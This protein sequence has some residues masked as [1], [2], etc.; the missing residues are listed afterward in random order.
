MPSDTVRS[1]LPDPTIYRF[2]QR[3]TVLKR[4]TGGGWDLHIDV[5]PGSI[6]LRY[7]PSV[8]FAHDPTQFSLTRPAPD[9]VDAHT[10][11]Y[12]QI[13]VFATT[14]ESVL[15]RCACVTD[16]SDFIKPV[17]LVTIVDARLTSE[18]IDGVCDAMSSVPHRLGQWNAPGDKCAHRRLAPYET[19][20]LLVCAQTATMRSSLRIHVD[21]LDTPGAPPQMPPDL[22]RLFA[23][24]PGPVRISEAD[25]VLTF[26]GGTVAVALLDA[27]TARA[28]MSTSY[29]HDNEDDL[30]F[31]QRTYQSVF[32]IDGPSKQIFIAQTAH[33]CPLRESKVR[34]FGALDD[35]DDDDG[36][37]FIDYRYLIVDTP[38]ATLATFAHLFYD[39]AT[40]FNR[41]HNNAYTLP[42]K[43]SL[44]GLECESVVAN[45]PCNR[46]AA[47]NEWM[48]KERHDAQVKIA[49]IVR[50]YVPRML[51]RVYRPDGSLCREA[52]A[53]WKNDVK[54]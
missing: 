17:W 36:G 31:V 15:G 18:M 27:R 48:R 7:T 22:M 40:Y 28:L 21:S 25:G 45:T 41:I 16:P 37:D 53:R 50:E 30:Q 46:F 13:H 43:D 26:A 52:G 14:D 29:D 47:R 8:S 51:A 5:D 35:D 10:A 32:G 23:R 44:V 3:D 9:A 49:R 39:S 34:E 20:R 38:A 12:G 19:R 1:V 4:R 2:D 11:T 33:V 24:A 6:H 42:D 54:K